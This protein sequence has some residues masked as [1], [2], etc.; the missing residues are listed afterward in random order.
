MSLPSPAERTYLKLIPALS[1]ALGLQGRISVAGNRF[2]PHPS[3]YVSIRFVLSCAGFHP[4][5]GHAASLSRS[6]HH[7]RLER[8][9]NSSFRAV[10]PTSCHRYCSFSIDAVNLCTDSYPWTMLSAKSSTHCRSR[11]LPGGQNT[12]RFLC[13]QIAAGKS[14]QINWR[15]LFN[16][17]IDRS[18][19]NLSCQIWLTCT[20]GLECSSF[21]PCWSERATFLL[22]QHFN[23]KWIF[24][25]MYTCKW[26]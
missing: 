11:R 16:N 19:D 5:P 14:R 12:H 7:Q 17:N 15:V 10:Y 8:G 23:V 4:E 26:Y 21:L 13:L 22:S 18:P 24:V 9:Q 1:R 6:G 20:S 2:S 25:F 3:Q